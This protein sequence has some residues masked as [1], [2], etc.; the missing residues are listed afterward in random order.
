MPQTMN[1]IGTWYYGKRDIA[2]LY[3]VCEFCK[4][5]GNLLS[6]NSTLYFVFFFIPLFP[7]KNL[8]I[9]FECPHCKMHRAQKLKEWEEAKREAFEAASKDVKESEDAEKIKDVLS[10]YVGYQ[11]VEG[12]KPQAKII[13]EKFKNNTDILTN[14][15]GSYSAFNLFGKA[16][17]VYKHILKIE[18]THEVRERLAILFISFFNAFS[19]SFG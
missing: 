15:G 9:M 16:E 14:L 13:R 17:E 1:G 19:A 2:S 3:G 11:D 4:K 7:L 10:L 8:R 12:F 6:Y 5:D 18:D